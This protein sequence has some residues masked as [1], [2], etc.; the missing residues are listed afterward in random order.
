MYFVSFELS[1]EH[2]QVSCFTRVGMDI[3]ERRRNSQFPWI[4]KKHLLWQLTHTH[5]NLLY[6]RWVLW[7]SR[8]RINFARHKDWKT[9]PVPVNRKIKVTPATLCCRFQVNKYLFSVRQ[10][11][12]A[13]H[14]YSPLVW[15]LLTNRKRVTAD[16]DLFY[17]LHFRKGAQR[18]SHD[19]RAALE[20]SNWIFAGKLVWSEKSIM[21]AGNTFD[22]VRIITIRL[23]KKTLKIIATVNFPRSHRLCQFASTCEF[24]QSVK[25][26]FLRAFIE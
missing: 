1:S 24:K 20:L 8:S 23:E 14:P 26:T 22:L 21:F 11:L 6:F 9:L 18:L 3:G 4:F 5:T 12:R 2:F 25:L 16:A 15:S 13:T 17:A 10:R 19:M 7:I